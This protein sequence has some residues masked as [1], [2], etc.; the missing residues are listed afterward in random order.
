[1]DKTLPYGVYLLAGIFNFDVV[2]SIFNTYQYQPNRKVVELRCEI[3]PKFLKII[4]PVRL[5]NTDDQCEKLLKY[6]L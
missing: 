5:I 2:E 4:R 3:L 1:M 6:I